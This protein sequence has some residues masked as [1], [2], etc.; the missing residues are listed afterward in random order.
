MN[1]KIIKNTND[2]ILALQRL[3]E[4]FDLN[5]QQGS[6]ENDELDVLALLIEQYE[7]EKFPIDRPTAIE[8]IKFRMDQ[9]GL[10]PKDL[11]P[12]IG[13]AP[14]VSEILNN[15]RSLS[16]SMIR[17]LNDGLK[18]PI[19]ILIQEQERLENYYDGLDY[20]LFPLN[21]IYKRSYLKNFHGTLRHL[22]DYASEY[23]GLFLRD[24]GFNTDL[25]PMLTRSTS[26]LIQNAKQCDPYARLI[27]Q[28]QI[29]HKARS[30]NNTQDYIVGTVTQAWMTEV[31]KLSWYESGP[32][33]AIEHLKKFGITVVLEK[34]LPKTYLDGAVCFHNNKPIIALTLRHDSIDNFW[35]TLMHEL[36][37]ISLHLDKNEKWFLD[38]L[39]QAN[40]DPREDEAN[41][42]ACEVL[43]PNQILSQHQY[44]EKDVIEI[45]NTLQISPC[46]VAG[47]FRYLS[48]NFQLF[49]KKF[50][51]KTSSTLHI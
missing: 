29:I 2:H 23:I 15:K 20:N 1:L 5:P 24:A 41:A 33:L 34:H 11:I 4:L 18:I 47:R 45:S 40:D 21:E 31:A 39:E 13:S 14:K 27:W 10:K 9:Q 7:M 6:V 49:G 19:D 30:L 26:S 42:L 16:L 46:I 12:Y 17:K 28:A 38:N 35:F 25:Q 32:N 3:T 36:A 8:A 43:I 37:H 51:A 22:K 48:N 44:T 50:R